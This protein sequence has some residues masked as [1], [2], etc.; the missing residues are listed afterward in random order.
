[1]GIVCVFVCVPPLL[2]LS[3]GAGGNSYRS[4]FV[5]LGPGILP[6]AGRE[7]CAADGIMGGAGKE[8]EVAGLECSPSLGGD[9]WK[10]SP[11]L[12]SRGGGGTPPILLS[13][14]PLGK[15]IQI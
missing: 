1:M 6:E 10:P 13:W 8:K 14:R 2:Q 7:V 15:R 4:A 9:F 12:K 11:A 3:R 5:I